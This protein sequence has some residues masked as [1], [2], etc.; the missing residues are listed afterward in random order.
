MLTEAERAEPFVPFTWDHYVPADDGDAT[1]W[2]W[3][4]ACV[5]STQPTSDTAVQFFE[6]CA[7]C[8]AVIARAKRGAWGAAKS[9][10]GGHK[11][12]CSPQCRGKLSAKGAN[13]ATS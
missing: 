1:R 9:R 7:V 6:T 12:V 11:P 4:R 13:D 8:G 3:C 10:R 2:R 5:Y